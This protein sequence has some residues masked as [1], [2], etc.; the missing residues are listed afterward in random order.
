MKEQRNRSRAVRPFLDYRI[1]PLSSPL[2]VSVEVFTCELVSEILLQYTVCATICQL[3]VHLLLI[4][5][6]LIIPCDL[7]LTNIS[8][9]FSKLSA[10]DYERFT[11]KNCYHWKNII[12]SMIFIH[13]HLVSVFFF[14][15]S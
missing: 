14:F 9:R 7:N 6:L 3:L 5:L 4:A 1:Q 15:I 12:D 8:N 11:N 13:Q 2:Q 10:M